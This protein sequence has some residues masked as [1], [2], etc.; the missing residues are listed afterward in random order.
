[1]SGTL[2]E[3]VQIVGT[4]DAETIDLNQGNFTEI[5]VPEILAIP[6][7]KP[8]VEQVLKVMLEGEITNVRLMSTPEGES[9]SGMIKT[10]QG[11]IVEGRL[12]QKIV[13][14][15]ETT[16][17]DQPVHSAEF[18]IPFS[19]FLA[20]NTCLEPGEEDDICV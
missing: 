14:V 2:T 4:C 16:E 12:H 6:S 1:M 17:E 11:L 3:L 9:S 5:A 7:Q 20:I 15:A 8:D 19:T 13:Y 10:G 18:D